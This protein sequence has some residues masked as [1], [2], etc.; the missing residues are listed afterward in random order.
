M[1]WKNRD[2]DIS[3]GVMLLSGDSETGKTTILEAIDYAFYGKVKQQ[4]SID[5]KSCSVRVEFG[6]EVW[7]QRTSGPG[8]FQLFAE[9][10]L[11]KDADAESL[12][13]E[14]YGTRDIFLASSYLKQGSTCPLLSGTNA[15]KMSLIRAISFQHGDTV[16]ETQNAIRTAL[17]E[18]QEKVKKL[19][20]EFALAKGLLEAFDKRL[21]KVQTYSAEKFENVVIPDLK[22]ECSDL[23]KKN[24]EII[25]EIS[26]V[27]ALESKIST[28]EKFI[29]S[30]PEFSSPENSEDIEK[31]FREVEGELELCRKA[32]ANK[33]ASSQFGKLREKLE[34]EVS[35]LSARIEEITKNISIPPEKIRAEIDR[36][37][38]NIKLQEKIDYILKTYECGNP[39]ELRTNSTNLAGEI[40]T[41]R[42]NILIMEKD[43]DSKEWN[44]TQLR[45]LVCPQC[46]S[47]LQV[48]EGKLIV[49]ISNYKPML[50]ELTYPD[51]SRVMIDNEKRKAEI[52]E[53]KK[54]MLQSAISDVNNLL[55]DLSFHDSED[56]K[57]LILY[58]D[59]DNTVRK[60]EESRKR[61][62][63]SNPS[64]DPV[65]EQI[66]T[67]KEDTLKNEL[68][69]LHRKRAEAQNSK[70]KVERRNRNIL[71][72]ESEKSK[73]ANRSSVELSRILRENQGA[74]A[75]K[76]E[77]IQ[78]SSEFLE[79]R[80]LKDAFD[81]K[82]KELTDLTNETGKISSLYERSRQVEIDALEVTVSILN[83]EIQKYV[84]IMFPEENM[85]LN[86]KTF[87]ESK[88][89]PQNKTMT[90][91]LSIFYK[92]TNWENRSLSGGA[93]DR[94]SLA[95]ML[96]LNSLIGSNILLLDETFKFLDR[97][98][99]IRIV[100]ML[101][102]VCGENKTCVVVGHEEVEGVYDS[103]TYLSKDL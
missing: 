66:Q 19:E 7:L 54:N 31:R 11:Y 78:S 23:E 102:Q 24:Q 45:T 86:F 36:I 27:S 57:K 85:I 61:L 34:K 18:S 83:S 67:E 3:P 82:D 65:L 64:Q 95:M 42:S 32:K 50:R 28:L 13:E 103:V 101:K 30:E 52:M 90:C 92:R 84:D 39:Q 97:N 59:Y 51:V 89:K 75:A 71:D 60:L 87:R 81:R 29:A 9:G 77:L 46:S 76:K 73:L 74:V 6:T 35:D 17:K 80:N 56:S 16:E 94:I 20:S 99:K 15:E 53:S 48:D 93:S 12:I 1:H 37:K 100:E 44:E 4:Y 21:P 14:M 22:K 49:L 63:E 68:D 72:L 91:S 25:G 2:F 41:L 70:A 55:K 40:R 33:E 5:E 79:R 96:A 62:G 69:E 88:T 58:E 38:K 47:A 98:A 8:S 10:K 26:V 43:L